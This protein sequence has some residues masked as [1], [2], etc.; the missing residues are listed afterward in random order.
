MPAPGVMTP[1][2]RRR[3]ASHINIVTDM[4]T[5][6]SRVHKSLANR[7][8]ATIYNVSVTEMTSYVKNTD[9]FT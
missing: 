4:S 6:V 1:S 3:G 5:L 9:S 7:R 8:D 2:S